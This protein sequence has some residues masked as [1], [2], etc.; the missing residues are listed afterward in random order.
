MRLAFQS[1]STGLL[2]AFS[3]VFQF[4]KSHNFDKTLPSL[5]QLLIDPL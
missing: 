4:A 2:E 1:R 3:G 5:V